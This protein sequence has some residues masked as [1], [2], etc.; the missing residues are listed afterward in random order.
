MKNALLVLCP[1]EP[2]WLP[3][4]AR[5]FEQIL[6][7]IQLIG[8][9]LSGDHEYLAGDRFLDLIAFMG[10]SPD[11]NLNPGENQH[12]CYIR[13]LSNSHSTQFH[14]GEHTHAP[15]CPHCSAAV[16]DWRAMN[17][18]DSKIKKDGTG[19]PPKME[20]SENPDILAHIAQLETARPGLVVG[21]AAETDDVVANA[22]AKRKRKGCDWIVANDVRPETGIMGGTAGMP[23][24]A[25]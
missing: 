11:I 13:L 15:R 9:P 10:C 19:A 12:F 7:S 25:E 17:T 16:A 8:E 23:S 18:T 20:L 3:A 4:D 2:G 1:A 5:G 6:E 14:C 22:T 24:A 21:F